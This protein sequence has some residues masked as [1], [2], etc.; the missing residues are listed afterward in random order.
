MSTAFTRI[1][2]SVMK[3]YKLDWSNGQRTLDK[4]C[5]SAV[6]LLRVFEQ[7]L[8]CCVRLFVKIITSDEAEKRG[9]LY[10][11]QGATYLFDLD[12]VEDVY[13]VDA[14]HHGNISHF[15]NHS[16]S[17]TLSY[18]LTFQKTYLQNS[19]STMS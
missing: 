10:D 9:H 13:T 19:Q 14:A 17:G 4:R 6:F 1:S 3:M 11:R 12:Y 8:K 7:F 15:V 5:A 16:V 2:Y 18:G